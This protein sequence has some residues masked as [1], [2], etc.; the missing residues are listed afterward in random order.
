MNSVSPMVP[1]CFVPRH[2][3]RRRNSSV[4]SVIAERRKNVGALL[5]YPTAFITVAP[6][7]EKSASRPSHQTK[8]GRRTWALV[9][10][11]AMLTIL[12]F[13]RFSQPPLT[14]HTAQYTPPVDKAIYH[15]SGFYRIG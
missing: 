2:V 15:W 10:G 4:H 12:S 11:I 14:F 9:A 3:E 7:A 8:W 13:A 5:V 6:Q 1:L